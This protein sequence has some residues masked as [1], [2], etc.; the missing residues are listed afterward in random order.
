MHLRFRIVFLHCQ[1][2]TNPMAPRTWGR[3]SS[4]WLAGLLLSCTLLFRR[5]FLIETSV[6]IHQTSVTTPTVGDYPRNLVLRQA[7]PELPGRYYKS[8]EKNW[9]RVSNG[10]PRICRNDSLSDPIWEWNL[11]SNNTLG[12]ETPRAGERLLIATYS[13]FG[14]YARLLELTAPINKAYA[15]KWNHDIVVLQGTSFTLL[16]DANC[17]PPE[18]RSRFNKI[19][20]L[21]E[22]LNQKDRYDLLLVLDADALIYDFSF[23]I[24]SLLPTNDTML[25]AQRTHQ[26]DLQATR[27]INNGITLWN[28]HHRLT[29]QVAQDWNKVAREGIPEN[30]PYRGDQ[31]YLREVLRSSDRISAISS[32]WDEFYYRDGTVVKHF[33]RSNSRSWNDTGL[34]VR[35]DRI[36]NTTKE[37]CARFGLNWHRLE[38][39]NYT[40][41]LGNVQSSKASCIPSD[42]PTGNCY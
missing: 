22:A 2:R 5:I 14:Q 24:A 20:L 30:R 36:M 15:K 8:T 25:V 1:R 41:I 19:D 6:V 38:R 33:Q 16:W 23:R 31:Y 34:D 7:A 37:I 12:S 21:L 42:N 28:L 18:E 35:E 13:A 11:F 26:D 3:R 29:S 17:T 10:F 9:S 40:D 4:V 39:R 27:S 32:V